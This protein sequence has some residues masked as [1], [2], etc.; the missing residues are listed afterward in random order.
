MEGRYVTGLARRGGDCSLIFAARSMY[1]PVCYLTSTAKYRDPL[2]AAHDECDE[3]TS[4]NEPASLKGLGN[5][6]FL[7]SS[8][9]QHRK[10][11]RASR[12]AAPIP[13]DNP[14]H[15]PGVSYSALSRDLR[16]WPGKTDRDRT[17]AWKRSYWEREEKNK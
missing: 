5:G 14:R 8:N 17:S 11:L 15:V 1:C 9:R 12:T 3:H 4:S 16:V 7:N 6:K 10:N 13:R 2:P